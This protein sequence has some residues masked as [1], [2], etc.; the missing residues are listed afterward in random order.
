LNK[1]GREIY[2]DKS[3]KWLVQNAESIINSGMS[4]EEYNDK[5]FGFLLHEIREDK[6]YMLPYINL[7]DLFS[8]QCVKT[9]LNNDRILAQKGAFLLFGLNAH[10]VEKPIPLDGS[11]EKPNYWRDDFDWDG[12][13]IEETLRIRIESGIS[14]KNLEYLGISKPYI[15]PNMEQITE[16]LVKKFGKQ[17]GEV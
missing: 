8:V 6:P 11:Y 12:V 10:D 5:F 16:H 9:K 15:Y 2:G 17:S 4:V 7:G 13:P 14:L 1:E 3:K